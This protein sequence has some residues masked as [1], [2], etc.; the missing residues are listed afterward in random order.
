M[1]KV[2]GKILVK[3]PTKIQKIIANT[4]VAIIAIDT[5]ISSIGYL[6]VF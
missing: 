3:I 4:L 6:G 1:I 5:L 2:I